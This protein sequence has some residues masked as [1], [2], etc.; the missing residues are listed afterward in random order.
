[1]R[2]TGVADATEGD[3]SSAARSCKRKSVKSRAHPRVAMLSTH[4][5]NTLREDRHCESDMN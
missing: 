2:A 5:V 3:S 1:M 4:N